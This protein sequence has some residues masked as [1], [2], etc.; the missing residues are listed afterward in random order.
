MATGSN[1]FGNAAGLFSNPPQHSPGITCNSPLQIL[2]YN[3][4]DS[5]CSS[6]PG[7]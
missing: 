7:N 3:L 6:P 2:S 5:L 1:S 4:P